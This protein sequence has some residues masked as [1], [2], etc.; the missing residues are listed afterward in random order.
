MRYFSALDDVHL[1]EYDKEEGM[2][3]KEQGDQ[4]IQTGEWN[5]DVGLL[6]SDEL[7]QGE[8]GSTSRM[9]SFSGTES[10]G[11]K[12]HSQGGHGRPLRR[13]A[14]TVR[15][16][17]G[18]REPGWHGDAASRPVFCLSPLALMFSGF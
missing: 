6:Q 17:K 18:R 13:Q 14:D 5:S 3:L 4:V 12:R 10:A 16:G 15:E 1:Q 7:E 8:K 9:E 2:W 11:G